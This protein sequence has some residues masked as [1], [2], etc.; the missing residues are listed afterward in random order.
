[1]V[2]AAAETISAF[3]KLFIRIMSLRKLRKFYLTVRMR[4][5]NMVVN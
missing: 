1:M 5:L 3:A 4:S 2:A